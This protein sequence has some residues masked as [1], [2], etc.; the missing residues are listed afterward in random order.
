MIGS[1]GGSPLTDRD[2]GEFNTYAY[3]GFDVQIWFDD[4]P[5][6]IDIFLRTFKRKIAVEL[7]R[8]G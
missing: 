3:A 4:R 5:R 7:D 6:T 1:G 8:S 2:V